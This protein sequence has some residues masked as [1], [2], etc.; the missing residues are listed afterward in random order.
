MS[1][2]GPEAASP[3]PCDTETPVRSNVLRINL[4]RTPV[5]PPFASRHCNTLEAQEKFAIKVADTRP[6]AKGEEIEG[7]GR[8]S[9]T[10]W[11][12][13]QKI[14]DTLQRDGS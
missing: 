4:N 12:N 11:Q 10:V 2:E 7:W 6:W 5:K 1:S 9:T 3:S 13:F 14:V 8:N